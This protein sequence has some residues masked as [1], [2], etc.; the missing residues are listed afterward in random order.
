MIELSLS[1]GTEIP[2]T[3]LFEA[4]DDL[5]GCFKLTKMELSAPHLRL[6][7]L[8]RMAAVQALSGAV[9]HLSL[10]THLS[11]PEDFITEGLLLH[12]S[13]LPRLETLIISPTPVTNNLL[14]EGCHGFGS[15]RSL[16]VPNENYLR[17]ML[18]YGIRDLEALKVRNLSQ[19]A[20]P[21]IVRELR[22]LRQLSIEGPSFTS[23]EMFI[24]GACFQLEEIEIFT[25]DPLG[26][27]DLDLD[28]FRTMFRNLRS[29]SITMRDC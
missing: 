18:S 27:E 15:L 26:M 2:P 10:L 11:L 24:L 5:Q 22:S 9:I 12:I 25:R 29:L 14:G 1:L 8:Q 16:E 20:L 28:R 17:R 23:L 4:L 3:E 6:D 21:V 7:A 19:H 13:L